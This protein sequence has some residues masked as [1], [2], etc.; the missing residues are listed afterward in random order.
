M[1]GK[2]I[3]IKAK[4][5]NGIEQV[6]FPN[7]VLEAVVDSETN[8]TLDNII[9]KLKH[10]GGA[11]YELSKEKTNVILTGSNGSFSQINIDDDG[12]ISSIKSTLGYIKKNLFTINFSS[13]VIEGISFT[14]NFD[15]NQVSVRGTRTDGE[16]DYVE[17]LIGTIFLQPG[18]YII[19]DGIDDNI[20]NIII[21]NEYKQKKFEVI[22]TGTYNVV[23]L[24]PV[25]VGSTIAGYII[26]PM[27]RYSCIEDESFEPPSLDINTR[28]ENKVSKSGDT[29]TGNLDIQTTSFP[30]LTLTRS[31]STNCAGIK[32][33][34]D[35]GVLGGFGMTNNNETL[36]RYGKDLSTAYTVLDSGNYSSYTLPLTGGTVTGATAFTGDFYTQSES[37][38]L[39]Q[40]YIVFNTN[41]GAGSTGYWKLCTINVTG[42]YAGAPI[43]F[44]M[45][46]RYGSGTLYLSFNGSTDI[47]KYTVNTFKQTGG[48]RQCYIVKTS[49]TSSGSV[50]DIYVAKEEAYGDLTVTHMDFPFYMRKLVAITWSGAYVASLP[51]GYTFARLTTDWNEFAVSSTSG[52]VSF[53]LANDHSTDY[54]ITARNNTGMSWAGI[55]TCQSNDTFTI[56]VITNAGSATASIS[57]TTF[58]LAFTNG[59]STIL[60][61]IKLRAN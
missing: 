31:G 23:A 43:K 7:T 28:I 25:S 33:A 30:A 44:D 61:Y 34:N 26:K 59:T 60:R 57:G 6:I 8:E 2:I 55:V 15:A 24:V 5:D 52:T 54:L 35:N 51:S 39:R 42:T 32:F 41:Q 11:T 13:T 18:I 10:N 3:P 4:D 17:C 40:D 9:D 49:G 22:N 20:V 37:T 14:P 1:S 45:T 21:D 27:I 16:G 12:T 29:M 46:C 53:S 36:T 38:Y 19:S 47:S 50:F 58:T 56:S 48:L